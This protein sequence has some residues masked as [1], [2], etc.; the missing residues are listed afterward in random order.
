MPEIPEG[1]SEQD[2]LNSVNGQRFLYVN[3][4]G[5]ILDFGYLTKQTKTTSSDIFFQTEGMEKK[6]VT[7]HGLPADFYLDTSGKIANIVVWVD[8]EADVLCY[9]SGYLWEEDL[10]ELA[11]SVTRKK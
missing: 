6:Q 5:E 7:V 1:Y 9:L 11:E 8:R 10:I 3:D 4:D 2:V